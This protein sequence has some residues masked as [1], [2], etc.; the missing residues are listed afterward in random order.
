MP[1]R[2][3]N[4]VVDLRTGKPIETPKKKSAKTLPATGAELHKWEFKPRFRRG[5]FG[6]KSQPAITRIRQAVSEI[7]KVARKDTALAGEGAVTFFERLSPAIEKVDSSS[8]SIGSAVN[9]AIEDLVPI[10]AAATVDQATREEWLDRLWKALEEDQMP[11]LESIG[12]YWGELCSIEELAS[13]WTDDLI[14]VVRSCWSD[15]RPGTFFHG[16]TACLSAL[17]KAGRNDELLEVLKLERHHMWHYQQFGARALANM[18]KVSEA[19]E[20]AETCQ[21]LH[22]DSMWVARTC[23]QILLSAGRI[24]EAYQ[25]Y[26]IAANQE[27]SYLSTYRAIAKKYSGSIQKQQILTDLIEASPGEEGKWFAAAKELGLLDLAAELA[28]KGPCDPK[29][30]SRAAR[31]HV[32]SNPMFA[33]DV[34]LAALSWL[35]KGYGY[36]MTSAD[37]RAAY[38]PTMKAARAIGTE[39]QVHGK[40]SEAVRLGLTENNWVAGI[41]APDFELS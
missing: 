20:F 32:E 25:H 15:D 29:T 28:R 10:I 34:G 36:E 9:K 26:A 6:W 33:I 12:D 38:D 5:S 23:E 13:K 19:I 8:G 11:Y 21:N 27:N 7:K 4:N 18:G 22:G 40:I 31:D 2:L 3:P 41:L 1:K 17:L 16:A 37:V 24:D 30:L 14:D 35:F 39:E